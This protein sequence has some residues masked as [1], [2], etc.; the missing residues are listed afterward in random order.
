M[1]TKAYERHKARMAE[2]PLLY[3]RKDGAYAGIQCSTCAPDKQ[4]LKAEG[5][6]AEKLTAREVW[7][8]GYKCKTCR[9]PET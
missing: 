8:S 7:N 4:G 9:Y 5:L 1:A 3:L 6:K 2:R